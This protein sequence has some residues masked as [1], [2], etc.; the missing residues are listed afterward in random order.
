MPSLV[1]D[2]D[3]EDSDE[4]E[5]IDY[6]P[7]FSESEEPDVEISTEETQ[8]PSNKSPDS[9][10]TEDGTKSLEFNERQLAECQTSE[11]RKFMCSICDK[12]MISWKALIRHKRNHHNENRCKFCRKRCGNGFFLK[13]HVKVEHP[14]KFNCFLLSGQ[15]A[16]VMIEPL[17]SVPECDTCGSKFFHKEALLLH[18]ADCDKKCIECGLKIPQRNFYFVHMEKEHNIKLKKH[19]NLECPFGC[20]EDFSSEKVLMEH[21]QRNHPEDKDDGSTIDSMSEGGESVSND[22]FIFQCQHCDARFSKQRSLSSHHGVMHK[23]QE[24]VAKTQNVRKYTRDEF[25][26]KFMVTK[27]NDFK[28]CIPCKKDIHRRSLA[29][30]IRGKHA[31]QKNFRCEL[32]PE[33]FFRQDYRMRHMTYSHINDYRCKTCE[34]HFDR[35]YKYDAHMFKHGVP[36]KNF[37]PDERLDQ[38]DL[39][40]ENMKFIEDSSTYDYSKQPMQRRMSVFGQ[41][42]GPVE[43]PLTKDEFVE[44]YLKNISDNKTYCTICQQGM[45]KGSIITHLF[46]KHALQKPLKCAFC[47]ERVVKNKLRLSHMNKCH[48]FE[49]R[50]FDCDQQFTKHALY[51]EHMMENHQVKVKSKPSSGEEDDLMLSEVRFVSQKNE[52]EII[53]EPEI[54]SMEVEAP[55]SYECKICVKTFSTFR[56]LKIHNS[57]KHK[58]VSGPVEDLTEGPMTFEE[59]RQNYTENVSDSVIKCIICM[60]TT[61][62]RNFANHVK[63]R[64][65]TTGAFRCAVCPESFFRPEHRIQ[66]MSKSH[67][68]MYFCQS[69][70]IQFY[71]NSRYAKHMKDQHE[72]EVD[73]SDQYDVDLNLSE[74]RFVGYVNKSQEEDSSLPSIVHHDPDDEQESETPSVETNDE[75]FTRD[76]FM[77]KFMKSVNKET[78]KC[79]ACDK[80]MLKGSI[81]NHLMTYHAK[82]YLFKCPFCEVRLERAPTRIRHLQ[83]FHP[84]DYKCHDCG[85]QFQKHSQFVDHMMEEHNFEVTT[86]KAPGEERDLSSLDVK[87][88]YQRPSEES[89]D[90][91][92]NNVSIETPKARRFSRRF[93]TLVTTPTEKFLKP[94]IKEEPKRPEYFMHSIFGSEKSLLEETPEKVVPEESY[95]SDSEY[96]YT[97]FKTRYVVD[98]DVSNVKCLPCNR[99]IIKTSVCAHLRLHHSIV[100]SYNC[101]LCT[102]GFQR[103]DYR[104]RHMK[105]SH[106][107]DYKCSYCNL[108]FYRSTLFREH[109]ENYHKMSCN[110]PELKT[111]EEI[112]VPLETM[113]FVTNL[114]E[115]LKVRPLLG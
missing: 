5:I 98:H 31:A 42:A 68:G 64:H 32:C 101:E 69:C 63:S 17:I 55:H 109:M 23:H 90:A 41:S 49:Y 82:T 102:D 30:H 95:S 22:S 10:I 44:K 6:E 73:S 59:F 18:H 81:Y 24:V 45:M 35:A 40:T 83:I 106:P 100:S 108:Q 61:K 3:E 27:S 110:V 84:D 28:R 87:Y 107:D 112:D 11:F 56:N 77:S 16:R 79:L 36:I 33:A 20:S 51:A 38:Y 91:D 21:V 65:A 67:R 54:I 74:L 39:L 1:I 86:P 50:C 70:N 99:P 113:K 58:D 4:H 103:S 66:H 25:V 53:E 19:S 26:E 48:P 47:N 60:Q 78:R 85:L 89:N 76:E 93:S 8:P 71:R 94:K 92:E 43:I 111:K 2:E 12:Q 88:V 75:E 34:V 96:N 104:M 57:H 9:G 52:E 97:D 115:A 80:T 72:I 114:S 13:M 14:D 7:D 62:K 29:C 15:T 105:H 46:W 37:K